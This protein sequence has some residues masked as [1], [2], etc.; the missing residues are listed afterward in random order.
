MCESVSM[1]GFVWKKN[2]ETVPIKQADPGSGILQSDAVSSP[3]VILDDEQYAVL[4]ADGARLV[5]KGV[6]VVLDAH[7]ARMHHKFAVLDD[8]VVTGSFN[9]TK[10]AS[11]SN[12][13]NLCILRDPLAVS[14]FAMEFQKLWRA[15]TDRTDRGLRG[16]DIRMPSPKGAVHRK[17]YGTPPR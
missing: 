2:D 4:G 17:R 11:M 6:P 10:Q 8:C 16:R 3:Q 5:E 14:P 9:W 13:E 7:E 15:F 12:W 1:F